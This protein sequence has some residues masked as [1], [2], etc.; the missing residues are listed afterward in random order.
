MLGV[1]Q[2]QD[3][4]TEQV[5]DAEIDLSVREM[6][7]DREERVVE[8]VLWMQDRVLL[9]SAVSKEGLEICTSRVL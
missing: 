2:G 4:R 3:L 7:T 9:R 5:I 6:S 1:D 8:A